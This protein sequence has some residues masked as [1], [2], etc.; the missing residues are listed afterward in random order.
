MEDEKIPAYSP[1]QV[2][3]ADECKS[4]K[5]N[6]TVKEYIGS[7]VFLF[8]SDDNIIKT[9]LIKLDDLKL[10]M[11]ICVGGLFGYHKLQIKSEIVDNKT[12][13]YSENGKYAY[14][15]V[16]DADDRHCWVCS[17]CANIDSIKKLDIKKTVGL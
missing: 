7:E 8:D 16:F 14:F 5:L 15:L 13:V 3:S 17:G 12:T 4:V 6:W 1:L 9:P 2:M 10:G 11:P